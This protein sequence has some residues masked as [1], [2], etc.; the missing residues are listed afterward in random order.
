MTH[1]NTRIAV[2]LGGLAITGLLLFAPAWVLR[3]L[4]AWA[5]G[6]CVLAYFVGHAIARADSRLDRDERGCQPA[7]QRGGNVAFHDH[8]IRTST[9]RNH[10]G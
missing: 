5:F 3:V 1:R 4:A 2:A 7:A 10:V 9:E 8:P 6:A